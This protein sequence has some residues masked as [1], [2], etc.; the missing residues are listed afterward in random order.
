[1]SSMR[2]IREDA[3]GHGVNEVKEIA[4]AAL[5]RTDATFT[6]GE[7]LQVDGGAHLGKW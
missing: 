1:M 2:N 5:F 7:I 3:R 4:D 6:T